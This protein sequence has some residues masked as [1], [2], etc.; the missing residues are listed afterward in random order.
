MTP[1]SSSGGS[2]KRHRT[3]EE[4]ASRGLHNQPVLPALFLLF[5]EG[6]VH[7]SIAEID[8][9]WHYVPRVVSG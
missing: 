6:N 2:M 8:G 5:F 9:L 1:E 7:I 3:P 4:L